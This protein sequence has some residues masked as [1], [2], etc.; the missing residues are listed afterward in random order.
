MDRPSCLCDALARFVPA[1]HC[2]PSIPAHLVLDFALETVQFLELPKLQVAELPMILALAPV[3]ELPAPF[4]RDHTGHC[5]PG[6]LVAVPVCFSTMALKLAGAAPKHRS[7]PL[8]GLLEV[9]RIPAPAEKLVQ[10]GFLVLSMLAGP[11]I[12]DFRPLC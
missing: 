6:L 12:A 8:A 11:M 9:A 2:G 4:H 3:L 1:L 5:H 7:C 10:Q